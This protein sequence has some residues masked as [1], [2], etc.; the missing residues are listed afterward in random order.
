VGFVLWAYALARMDVGRATT[1]LYL[2]PAAAILIALVWL[3]Q[4]PSPLELIG[5]GIA[6]A[7]V[8]L[9][10]GNGRL[11]TGRFRTRAARWWCA[12]RV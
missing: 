9:A 2:A 10:S 1:A 12:V 3:G 8:V 6:L 4:V 5:G 11:G 7:G